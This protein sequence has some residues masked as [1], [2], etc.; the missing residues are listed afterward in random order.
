MRDALFIRGAQV[1]WIRGRGGSGCD[2]ANALLYHPL[3][4]IPNFGSLSDG[5]L[6]ALYIVGQGGKT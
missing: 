3:A 6:I 1:N 2:S 5:E 4:Q